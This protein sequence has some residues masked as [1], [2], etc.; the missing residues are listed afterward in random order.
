MVRLTLVAMA[1]AAGS[2]GGTEDKK[3]PEKVPC[4]QQFIKLCP[5]VPLKERVR[6]ALRVEKLNRNSLSTAC[7]VFAMGLVMNSH[8]ES[9][10]VVQAKPFN[11][12]SGCDMLGA[13]PDAKGRWWRDVGS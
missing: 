9:M 13:S 3:K 2:Q 7:K 1:A 5:D 4:P 11:E 8:R 12:P 6:C 10:E